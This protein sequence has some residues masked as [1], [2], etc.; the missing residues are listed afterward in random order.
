MA[1]TVKFAA[2]AAI[3]GLALSAC[4]ST[5]AKTLVIATDLPLQGAAK[6][7]NDS[8]N[9][10]IQLYLEQIDEDP[11]TEGVQFSGYTIEL[12]TYDNATAAKGSWDD[13][14]CAKNASDHVS[15]AAEVAVMGT[16]NSG[17]AKLIVPVLNEAP[18][19]PIL[20]VSHANTNPGLTKAWD[21]GE[22]DVYYPSGTRSYARVATTD[23]YQGSAAAQ[24][25]AQELKV[26]KCFVLND[27]QT[28]GQGVAKAFADEAAAQGITVIANVAWDAAAASYTSLFQQAKDAGADCVY[29]GGIYDN[30]GGALM[31]DKVAVLGDNNAVKVLGPDGFTGYPDFV[32]NP[33]AEGVYLTFAGLSSDLLLANGGKPAE[34]LEAYKTKYGAEP[35]GSYPLYGVAAV[36]VI[37]E[38][39]K[40]SDGTRAG[41]NGAVFPG[42]ITVPA[43]ISILGKAININGASGDVDLIDITV[44]L[45]TGGKETTKMAWAVQ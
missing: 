12:K 39:I 23:D 11:N 26:T 44:E 30:N 21:P 16:Y 41:V 20:M 24:F 22:P 13:A 17:C 34:F 45:V 40:A 6:D 32:A 7:A 33:N 25:A 4:G 37:L 10:A 18:D 31:N 29:F 28:Y 42:G 36:Q 8:T 5:E 2:L 1:K 35:V 19:G 38:A 15:N 14:A 43:D 3:A 9:M 27:N